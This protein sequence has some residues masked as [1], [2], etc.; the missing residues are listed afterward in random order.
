LFKANE[1]RMTNSLSWPGGERGTGFVSCSSLAR[2]VFAVVLVAAVCSSGA[3]AAQPPKKP[4]KNDKPPAKLFIRAEW[5]DLDYL[6]GIAAV[7]GNV[8]FIPP[9][10]GTL[11]AA[12]AG[13]IW[14]NQKEAYL[15]GNIRVYRTLP[16]MGDFSVRRPDLAD[17]TGLAPNES[18]E[19]GGDLDDI[20][21]PKPRKPALIDTSMPVSEADR[22][23]VNWADGTAYLVQPTMRMAEADRIVNWVVSAPSAEGIATYRIPVHDKDGN[24]TGRY[25][26]RSHYVMKNATFTTCSFKKP[27]TRFTATHSEMIEGDYVAMYNILLWAEGVPIFYFPFL[28]QDLE[29]EWP[30]VKASL[31]HSSR[32][33]WF[34][35]VKVRFK[36]TRKLEVFPRVEWMSERGV[37]L[38]LGVEYHAG[39]DDAVRS[40]LDVFWLPHDRGTDELADTSRSGSRWR[41]WWPAALGPMPDDL[42]LRIENRYRVKLI[43]QQEHPKGVE[44]DLEVHKFSDAGVYR[45][46]FEKEFKT[47]K[48]PETRALLKYGRDNWAVFVHLKKRINDFLSQTEYLPQI[49]F[50][51]IGQPLGGG[52]LFTTDTEVARVTTRYGDVRRR[53]GQSR[54]A[55][56]RIWLRRNEYSMPRALTLRENDTD[57]LTGWRFDT[58]N[59]ISYPFEVSIFDIEPYVGW[60][61][62]WFQH[63]IHPRRGSY[64]GAPPPTPLPPAV[65][66]APTQTGSRFRSQLLAGGRIATQ[67]H[68]TYDVSH[69]P[70]L[71]QIFKHGMRHIVTPE[72]TYTFESGPAVK[73]RHLPRND[74][75]TEQR[76]MH[77]VN[78]ALRNRWQTRWPPEIR[79]H[80]RAPV[81]GEWYRRKLAVKKSEHAEPVDIVDLDMDIDFFFNPPRDNVY[82]RGRRVRRWSNLRTDLTVR[83]TRSTS[84]FFDT[85]FNVSGGSV[86]EV[87]SAGIRY[88][89]SPAFGIG[90]SHSYHID[91][92]S[93][94]RFM[95]DWEVNPKWH[96][97]FDVQQDFAGG[98][99]WDRVI[100]I[101]RRFHE[102]EL[103]LGY[104]FDKGKLETI[105]TV[106]IGPAR[107]RAAR[108]SWRFQPRSVQAFELAESAR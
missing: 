60:R 96:V 32:L 70:F 104:E 85:E 18:L 105:G 106:H 16:K 47:E 108:P 28:Y 36:P 55:I 21:E 9:D 57:R 29:Y 67:F 4:K 52:F 1:R 13:V 14:L 49:G 63:G 38:G 46:Y 72:V 3:Y 44:F 82:P 54:V 69:R 90:L 59:T 91:D 92:A 78:L 17:R 43:H 15:E 77:K 74:S 53:L 93:L 34:T 51:M 75:V 76:G 19:L 81:G 48:A 31:G 11:I 45:E 62:S 50:N 88:S 98:G 83:P 97:R 39:H 66:A 33:G 30:W 73:P 27:H 56:T 25:E 95:A 89:P 12:D 100:E 79:R 2:G 8:R 61:G 80:P 26:R 101:T 65:A 102:W 107:S 23:Y 58:V 71:R 20:I 6:R 68:R 103:T 87:L 64:W 42:P 84:L 7:V 35:S 41:A 94:L 22:I 40:V 86:L 37:A 24:P 5:R 99:D 10:S